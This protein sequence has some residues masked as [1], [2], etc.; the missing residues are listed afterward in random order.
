MIDG[1]NYNDMSKSFS[2]IWFLK[3]SI[4]WLTP[5]TENHYMLRRLRY[6]LTNV[7]FPAALPAYKIQVFKVI[8]VENR[9]AF[10][11]WSFEILKY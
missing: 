4:E 6:E 7:G 10:E 8:A 11:I 2:F 3:D 9:Q 1:I 5:L